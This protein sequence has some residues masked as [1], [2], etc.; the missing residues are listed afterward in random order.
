MRDVNETK[1]MILARVAISALVL[2]GGMLLLPRFT[3][4]DFA[5]DY[6]A[7]WGWRHG[8]DVHSQTA[9]LL[10]RCC[11]E[12]VRFYPN[13][14][15]A[16]PPL[17]TLLAL[18]LA[19][20]PWAS[21]RQAWLLISWVAIAAGWQLGRVSLPIMAATASFW[22]IALVLGTHEPLLFA[23]LVTALLIEHR[24]PLWAGA[25]LGLCAAL[26][27]Y[28]ALLLLGL[29]ISG[30]RRM[31]VAGL[32]SGAAAA[33]LA[34]L[35]LGWGVTIAWLTYVP[36]NTAR[37]VDEVSNLS[38][39]RLVRQLQ[40]GASPL[41]IGLAAGMLLILPLLPRLRRGD[42]L[43]PLVPVMLL[44]SPLSWRHYMGILAIGPI[45]RLELACL[46]VAGVVALL[47]GLEIIPAENL[48]PV[49]QGP[50]LAALA[51][52]WYRAARGRVAAR[53]R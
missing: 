29:L 20:L 40:P 16:H 47:V 2:I 48:A 53:T 19:W 27:A 35:T 51:A 23:L 21:A 10:G 37:Y 3:T 41:L 32:A 24:A 43:R 15:T 12:L 26:K 5:Q 36:I 13:M 30:R 34:E 7:A 22:V 17:A 39:V 9:D 28:P 38:L 25:L 14:Q 52:L 4:P 18:P 1:P 44:I 50:L 33:L 42:A 6:A 49:V 8:L 31:V 45:A 46:A 11:P